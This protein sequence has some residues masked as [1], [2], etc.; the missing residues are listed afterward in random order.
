MAA[1]DGFALGVKAFALG[2]KFDLIS[3][4]PVLCDD[5]ADDGVGREEEEEDAETGVVT[6]DGGA[7]LGGAAP[8]GE[9][10]T[11]VPPPLKATGAAAPA[12]GEDSFLE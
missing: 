6:A 3:P 7:P 10:G 8:A 4:L 1:G 12:I 5:D 2:F 9:E 11:F